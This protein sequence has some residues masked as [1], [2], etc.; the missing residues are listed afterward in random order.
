MPSQNFVYADVDGHIG[1]YL[2]G[3]IPIRARAATGPTPADGWTGEHGVDR[4]DS[5]RRAAAHLRSARHFIVTANN[6]PMPPDYPYVD[7]PRVSRSPIARSGSPTCCAGTSGLTPDDM[8]RIQADTYSL[9]AQTLL[10]L[11]LRHVE[12]TDPDDQ[13]GRGAA[14]VVELRRQR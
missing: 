11:L 12:P 4:L 13:T 10:P 1:Y 3:R 9:H 14:R 8:R 6:R 5:V 2:P 7:R